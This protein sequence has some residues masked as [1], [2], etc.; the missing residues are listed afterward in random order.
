MP[1]LDIYIGECWNAE[2][3]SLEGSTQNAAK[4]KLRTRKKG[5]KKH[6]Y[7]GVRVVLDVTIVPYVK[8]EYVHDK[9][10]TYITV[11]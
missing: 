7:I 3:E 4:P 8:Y 6:W 11:L 10:I 5:E 1:R 2:L 9:N